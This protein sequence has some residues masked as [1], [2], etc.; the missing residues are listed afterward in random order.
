MS[1]VRWDPFKNISTLQERINSLFDESF[2]RSML[3]NEEMAPCAWKPS[4][5]IYETEKC[6]VVVAELPGVN[7]EDISVEV[8][9]NILMLRGERR[10]DPEIDADTYYRR[11]RCFGAFHRAF[12]LQT[13]VVPEQI[14]ARFKGGV[15]Q[16]EIAKPE[17]ERPKQIAVDVD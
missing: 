2:P 14:K 15:L 4:V 5:D 16:I 10:A 8:K 3:S 11:E 9:N 1:V 12:N 7:K 13:R 6:I 17:E